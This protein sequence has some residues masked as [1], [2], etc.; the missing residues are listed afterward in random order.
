MSYKS[1]HRIK[2]ETAISTIESELRDLPND[3]LASILDMIADSGTSKRGLSQFDNFIVSDFTD[4]GEGG[5]H[6]R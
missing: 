5:G 2:R 4:E 6:A 3:T 1:T